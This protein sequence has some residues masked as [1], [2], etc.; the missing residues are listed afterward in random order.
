MVGFVRWNQKRRPVTPPMA[1]KAASSV[2]ASDRRGAG[3]MESLI[4]TTFDGVNRPSASQMKGDAGDDRIRLEQEG[5]FDEQRTLIVKQVV[6]PPCGHEFRQ[7]NRDVIV[8]MLRVNALDV[9]EQRL[10]QRAER[11]IEHDERHSVSP[12][13]PLPSQLLR[14]NRVNIDIDDENVWRTL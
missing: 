1:R 6:P 4:L 13:R 10:H 9:F 8:W 14:C 3:R 2:S 7:N 12:L 11:R 5:A